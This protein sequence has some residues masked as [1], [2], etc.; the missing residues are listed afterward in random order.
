MLG[1]DSSERA[2]VGVLRVAED[3]AGRPGFDHSPVVEDQHVVGDRATTPRSCVM[4]SN[5]SPSSSRS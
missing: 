5:A 1:A 2:G 3:P 4:N